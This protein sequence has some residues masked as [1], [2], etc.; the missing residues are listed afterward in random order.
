MHFLRLPRA[1][2]NKIQDKSWVCEISTVS[3]SYNF[4]TSFL[5]ISPA[6]FYQNQENLLNCIQIAFKL[7]GIVSENVSSQRTERVLIIDVVSI[8]FLQL[9]TYLINIHPHTVTPCWN[10]HPHALWETHLKPQNGVMFCSSAKAFF[11]STTVANS[12]INKNCSWVPKNA[13]A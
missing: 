2:N 7:S 9:F 3:K 4:P 6:F 12:T 1:G 13:Q 8:N 5:G 10:F 11:F